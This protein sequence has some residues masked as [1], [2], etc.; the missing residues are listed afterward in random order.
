MRDS[1][2]ECPRVLLALDGRIRVVLH[3]V[4]LMVGRVGVQ[5]VLVQGLPKH[6]HAVRA[7]LSDGLNPSRGAHMHHVD[8]SAWDAR[9][10]SDH[11]P[12]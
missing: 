7:A 2:P 4:R 11:T 3:A 9:G 8:H 5:G 10:E 12:K 6:R 1:F